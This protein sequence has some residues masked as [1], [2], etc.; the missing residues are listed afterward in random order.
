MFVRLDITMKHTVALVTTGAAVSKI[1]TGNF[2]SKD[3]RQPEKNYV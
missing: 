3:T 1:E 2:N